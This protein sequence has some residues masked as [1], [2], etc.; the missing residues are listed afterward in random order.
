[1]SGFGLGGDGGGNSNQGGGG[2][3][4]YFDNTTGPGVRDPW[5]NPIKSDAGGNSGNGGSGDNKTNTD[6]DKN[7]TGV[8]DDMIDNI[9][10]AHKKQND[11]NDQNNNN[12]NNQNNNNNNNQQTDTR[13]QDQ[14]MTDYLKNNGLDPVQIDDQM[15]AQLESGDF[16]GLVNSFNSRIVN[17]HIKALSGSQTMIE[18]AVAKKAKE[19]T[20]AST[21]QRLGEQNRSA[22]HEAL[23]FTKDSA[24]S[25]VAQSVMQRFLDRD[26]SQADAIEGTKKYFA[27]LSDKMNN[28]GTNKNRN[29]NFSS[30]R[31]SG[32]SDG[33]SNWLDVLTGHG[34]DG[35]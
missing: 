28:D 32:N 9:W 13:T 20:D 17:A 25:P 29:T 1:M 2:R 23:P 35:R 8:D 31:N 26:M 14:K 11:T 10:S 34:R 24:I 7:K 3:R 22:M 21:A 4:P 16:S 30:Q 33:N 6:V 5:N 12:N 15:K 19:L 18:A 27:R